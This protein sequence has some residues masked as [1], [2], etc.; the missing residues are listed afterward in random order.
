MIEVGV[1]SRPLQLNEV[2]VGLGDPGHGGLN[3]FF[4][5]VRNRNH[6]K[7]VL[8]IEYDCFE[9]LAESLLMEIGREAVERW[10]EL[11]IRILHSKGRLNIGDVCVGIGVSSPHRDEAFLA[12]RYVIEELKKRAPI[13][14][15]VHWCRIVRRRGVRRR[16]R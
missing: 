10:G 13:W 2:T 8:A 7:K 5:A 14:K 11:N 16:G 4:G 1:L 9:P 6:G 3:F 15:S 12:C